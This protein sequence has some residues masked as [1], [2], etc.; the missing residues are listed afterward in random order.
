MAAF[1]TAL[2]QTYS[3]A[4]GEGHS[5]AAV[6]AYTN[7]AL[8]TAQNVTGN[9]F[10]V[11]IMPKNA[12]LLGLRVRVTDMDSGTAGLIDI[13][14]A[15]SANRLLAAFTIQVAGES[16]TL[17]VGAFLYKYTADTPILITINTQSGTAVAGTISLALTYVVDEGFSTTALVPA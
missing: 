17:P 5:T 6:H 2:G 3:P 10:S 9:T 13:G 14:D 7:V 11:F 4:R 12:V 1:K 16:T 15:A 8:S